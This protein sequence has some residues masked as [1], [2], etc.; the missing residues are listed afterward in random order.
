[1]QAGKVALDGYGDGL[2]GEARL[3][4][5]HTQILIRDIQLLPE[6]L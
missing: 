3:H 4:V 2:V 1:M 5:A 6:H